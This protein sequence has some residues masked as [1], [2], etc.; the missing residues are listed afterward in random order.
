MPYRATSMSGWCYAPD[1]LSSLKSSAVL[2]K[3][4]SHTVNSIF[5]SSNRF[6]IS[7]FRWISVSNLS[8]V[9]YSNFSLS[10]CFSLRRGTVIPAKISFVHLASTW[11]NF[12]SSIVLRS[13]AS[14]SVR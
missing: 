13:L 10:P 9:S 7:W 4:F 12:N 3:S 1:L 2:G 8:R 11:R 5:Y 6:F 14:V